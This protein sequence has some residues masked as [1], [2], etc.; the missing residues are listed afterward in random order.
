ME[1]LK[2]QISISKIRELR[3]LYDKGVSQTDTAEEICVSLSTV[4]KYYYSFKIEDTYK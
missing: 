2:K 3:K 4:S 1:Y